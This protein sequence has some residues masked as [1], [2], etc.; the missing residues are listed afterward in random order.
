LDAVSSATLA[1]SGSPTGDLATARAGTYTIT[2]SALALSPGS[3]SN[4]AITYANGTL[5]ISAVNAT[6]TTGTAGT[7]DNTSVSI[8]GSNVTADGGGTVT[9]R[10]IA[11]GTRAFPTTAN[12]TTSDGTGTGSFNTNLTGLTPGVRYFFRAYATNAAG[13][14]YGAQGNFTTTAPTPLAPVLSRASMATN[15][16]N[17]TINWADLPNETSYELQ[18]STNSTF[19]ANTSTVSGIA[20]GSTSRTVTLATGLHFVRVRGINAGG[21]GTWSDTQ[22]LQVQ[23][24]SPGTTRYLSIPGTAAGGNGTISQVFGPNNESGLTAAAVSN[25]TTIILQAANGSSQAGAWYFGGNWVRTGTNVNN[26]VI[27]T[28]RAFMLRN[29]SNQ[30]DHIVI[31]GTAFADAEAPTPVSIT[32]NVT[33]VAPASTS[34]VPLASSLSVTL[35]SAQATGLLRGLT[36]TTTPTAANHFKAGSTMSQADQISV[37]ATAPGQASGNF[38]YCSKAGVNSWCNGSRKLSSIP[39]I[40]PASV[41]IIRKGAGSTLGQWTPPGQ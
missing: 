6:I 18:H 15:S 33:I 41:I 31:S 38:W 16:L 28:G 24:L 8:T 37:V 34:P 25:S 10:G 36:I 22:T 26:E 30:T 21:N 39:Q 29:S 17:V 11:Y 23:T 27:P 1:Y 19:S 35:P 13:T 40:S 12:S 5:T 14:A 9:A 7:P 3:A 20:A 2:P 32:S 4:Y